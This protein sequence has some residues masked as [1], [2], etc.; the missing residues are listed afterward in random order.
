MEP[1]VLGPVT[2]SEESFPGWRPQ[3]ERLRESLRWQTQ[4]ALSYR[5]PGGNLSKEVS[6]LGLG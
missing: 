3:I 5:P 1:G 4:K 2:S 6:Q